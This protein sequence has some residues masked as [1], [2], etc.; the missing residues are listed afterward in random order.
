ME[1]SPGPYAD[2]TLIVLHSLLNIP[3]NYADLD[4]LFHAHWG[5]LFHAHLHGEIFL[6]PRVPVASRPALPAPRLTLSTHLYDTAYK[7]GEESVSPA[8]CR[9]FVHVAVPC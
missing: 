1:T 8:S 5:F 4:Y 3:D 7:S 9:L 2:N 6:L